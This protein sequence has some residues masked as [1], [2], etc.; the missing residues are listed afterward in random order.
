MAYMGS[1]EWEAN[2]DYTDGAVAAIHHRYLPNSVGNLC[3]LGAL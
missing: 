3:R 1:A 2:I